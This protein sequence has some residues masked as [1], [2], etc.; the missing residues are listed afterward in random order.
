MFQW[1]HR[2]SV[3]TARPLL[4][5]CAALVVRVNV[6]ALEVAVAAWV[7]A[8]PLAFTI[9]MLLALD[10]TTRPFVRLFPA[11]EKPVTVHVVPTRAPLSPGGAYAPPTFVEGIYE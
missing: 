8:T 11:L 3:I 5:V 1:V 4:M 6:V 10:A 7:S 9:V 2:L